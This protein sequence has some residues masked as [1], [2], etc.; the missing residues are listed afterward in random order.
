MAKL[1]SGGW[2]RY[3]GCPL[4]QA[5]SAGGAQGGFGGGY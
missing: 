2:I 1:H 4:D 5:P 3:Y